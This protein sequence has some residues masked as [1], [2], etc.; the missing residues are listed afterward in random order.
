MFPAL[1]RSCLVASC[2]VGVQL[3]FPIPAS[4]G[5]DDGDG[6]I[7]VTPGD[8]FGEMEPPRVDM[9]AEYRS[10][11]GRPGERTTGRAGVTGASEESPACTIESI[12]RMAGATNHPK[13]VA[14]MRN[15][16]GEY[17]LGSRG[18]DT[19]KTFLLVC[20]GTPAGWLNGTGRPAQ[21]SGDILPSAAELAERARRE[22]VLPL[23]EPGMSPRVRL[24]DGRW[25]T[26]VREPTWVWVDP[27][28]WR[29]R[30]KRVRVGPV[31]AEVSAR[32]RSL[33]FTAMGRVLS[34]A[35]AGTPYE[36][37]YG[38]HAASPDCGLRFARS[39][40]G[41]AVSAVYEITWSVSWRGST[42]G[43][44]EGGE[45]PDMVSRASESVV[46]AEAQSLRS[47]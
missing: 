41:A 28:V 46:V 26:L 6:Q 22:L 45:L 23:P 8:A 27:G 5:P 47:R 38:V 34:C 40:G 11:G 9:G 18:G 2:L 13:T 42:G 35:G 15:L 4:A 36:R 21:G 25:A 17:Y 30:S 44:R 10:T 12:T 1:V 43:T 24:R 3:V 14:A 32:P 37:L 39:S 20:N 16:F 33:R 29:E 31:W 7:T 19:S